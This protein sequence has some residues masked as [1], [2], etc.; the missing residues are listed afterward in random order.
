MLAVK[1]RGTAHPGISISGHHP[2]LHAL[3]N[4][5]RRYVWE[6]AI[7]NSN[8]AS[9]YGLTRRK[10]SFAGQI[11]SCQ[12]LYLEGLGVGVGGGG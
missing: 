5:K 1:K 8:P 11:R 9:N 7:S 12:V 6:K 3:H 2:A 10:N 4:C